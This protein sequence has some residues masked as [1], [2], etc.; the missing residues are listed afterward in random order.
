DKRYPAV[1]IQA[2]RSPR[3]TRVGLRFIRGD[4]IVRS[5]EDVEF[6]DGP[7]EAFFDEYAQALEERARRAAK[8]GDPL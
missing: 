6:L 3:S 2:E 7:T 5:L 1:A 4:W 8:R